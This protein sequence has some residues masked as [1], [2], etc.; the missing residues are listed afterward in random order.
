MAKTLQETIKTY[1]GKLGTKSFGRMYDLNQPKSLEACV[2]WLSNHY[3]KI[4][5]E[6]ENDSFPSEGAIQ[7]A[8]YFN[9]KTNSYYASAR[10]NRLVIN[11]PP[12]VGKHMADS[13]AEI[14]TNFNPYLDPNVSNPNQNEGKDEN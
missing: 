13:L 3:L 12:L 5:E 7:A 9:D 10:N 14:G 2:N 1:L 11:V 6:V 4:K 8:R